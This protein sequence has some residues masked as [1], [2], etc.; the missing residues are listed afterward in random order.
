MTR[1]FEFIVAI[2]MVFIL[3]VIVGVFLPSHGHIQRS[4]QISHDPHQTYDLLNNFR[5]FP[6]YSGVVLKAEDP[7]VKI[8]VSGAPYGPGAKVSWSGDDKVGDN[9]LTNK[10]G[11]LDPTGRGEIVWDMHGDWRGSN[12][13]FTLDL[14]PTNSQRLTKLTW[15]YDVD[16]GWNLIN[17]Y[18]QFFLRG[19]PDTLIQYS[20]NNVQN[21][22]ASIPNIDYTKIDMRIVP[23]QPQAIL[24]VST[25]APRTLDDVDAATAKAMGQIGAAMRKLGV[26]QAGPR[27]TITTDYGDENYVFDVAVPIDASSLT[28]NGQTVDLTKLTAQ[29]ENAPGSTPVSGSSAAPASGASAGVPASGAS[30]G[31]PASG[32]STGAP[33]APVLTPGNVDSKGNLVVDGIV[34]A[35]MLPGGPV[36]EGDWQGTPAGIPL[37]RL[38][39]KAYALTHGYIFDDTTH[40]YYDELASLPNVAYDQQ[41]FRVFLPLLGDEPAQTPEQASGK[42]PPLPALDPAVWQNAPAAPADQNAANAKKQETKK[43]T[44]AKH[45]HR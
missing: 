18:S 13:L 36:L 42:V 39:L 19:D 35:A 16:Y 5:R 20:L 10:S 15:S 24:F 9:T 11:N 28:V 8:N 14:E 32:G 1:V 37:M 22:L 31:A 38:A 21:T 12:K 23:T 40:R 25:Q 26:H 17:R 30:S 44:A 33:P 29:A 34:R 4:L 2:I 27:I 41:A 45:K 3:A 6:D 7:Q 43:K